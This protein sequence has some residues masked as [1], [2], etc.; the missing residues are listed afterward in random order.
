[1]YAVYLLEETRF[2][3]IYNTDNKQQSLNYL[4]KKKFQMLLSILDSC[5]YFYPGK[6]LKLWMLFFPHLT[7]QIKRPPSI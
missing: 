4:V 3:V 7:L 5:C 2:E 1:M 6:C